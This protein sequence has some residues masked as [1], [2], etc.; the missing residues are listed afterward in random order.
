M[1]NTLPQYEKVLN[2]EFNAIY[3]ELGDLKNNRRQYLDSK[4]IYAIYNKFLD[5]LN[6]LSIIRKD[7]EIKGMKLE[8][9]NLNDSVVDDIWQLISLCF[10]TCGLTK[11]APATY[12]SLSTVYKLLT[13]L[14][15]GKLY[16][17]D[18]LTPI[19]NRLVEIKRIIDDYNY[20]DDSQD[21]DSDHTTPQ[22]N[23]QINYIRRK[24]NKCQ[25]LYNELAAKI[26]D[27]PDDV[28]SIYNSLLTL[29]KGLIG[30][31]IDSNAQDSTDKFQ[32]E[33]KRVEDLRDEQGNFNNC[34]DRSRPILDGLLDDCNNLIKDININKDKSFNVLFSKLGL[35]ENCQDE[36]RKFKSL[37]DRLIDIKLNLENLLITRRWT[38]RE[39]DL[40]NFQN[41]LKDIET[42]RL[43]ILSNSSNTL[44][45]N[46]K[47][48]SIQVLLLYLL[49]RCYSLIY[50]LLESSEPVSES[51][52]PIHNQ[53]STVRRCLLDIKRIDGLNNLRE[54]Y[55]FQFKLASLDNLRN[56][57][58]FI[59]NNQIPEGQ[60]T[61]NAL[62]AECFDILHELKIELEAKEDEQDEEIKAQETDDEDINSDDEV[63]LK[64]NRYVEFNEA[65]YDQAEMDSLNDVDDEESNTEYEAND[66]Y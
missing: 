25:D 6:E 63:E 18:D 51:L 43:D 17:M 60:G 53:L 62:L 16:T 19:E 61:L 64:R 2:T 54:L 31:V 55:P 29:R 33:L 37:I 27:I 38:L 56:D 26:K 42:T 20:Q 52:Q 48:K 46:V 5:H 30:L 12:S 14:R 49:R 1:K 24:Y 34:D 35:D 66:Y 58:K 22:K 47:F 7:E 57:G 32:A 23:E 44:K 39:T 13:H 28:K 8:L 45:T 3:Q 40:Y 21:E 9:P 15:D 59:I 4:Q 41:E 36:M 11:F 10:I 65:D 50:K